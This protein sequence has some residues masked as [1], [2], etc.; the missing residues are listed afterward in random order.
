VLRSSTPE[1]FAALPQM[2]FGAALT[3]NFSNGTHVGLVYRHEDRVLICHMALPFDL[4]N[5][6]PSNHYFWD[7]SPLSS[8]TQQIL[9]S[10]LR[11]VAENNPN[12]IPYG[13]GYD[14]TYFDGNGNFTRANEIGAGLNC[15]TFIMAIYQSLEIPLLREDS[16]IRR[17]E[18]AE[19]RTNL[20]AELTAY[21][22]GLDLT[23]MAPFIEGVRF[24]PEE[25]AAG[26]L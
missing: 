19:A 21:D 12:T 9:V 24:R 23:P 15:A 25:V 3:L 13:F 14:G 10:Y 11:L 5:Q 4:R 7:A 17:A 16:W 2:G 6:P 18:D 8:R 20:I 22:P 1:E 26:V